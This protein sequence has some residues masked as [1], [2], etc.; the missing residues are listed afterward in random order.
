MSQT[1]ILRKTLVLNESFKTAAENMQFD[2]DC[3]ER[4]GQE[5]IRIFRWYK[6]QN[7][8]V[9]I[10]K[11]K[12]LPENLNHINYSERVS[13]GG[14]VFH[15]PNDIVFSITSTLDDERFPKKLKHKMDFIS[16]K[17]RQSLHACDI[18]TALSKKEEE[19]ID[20]NFCKSYFNPSE[21]TVNNQKVCG[22]SLRKK[23]DSFI[24]QGVI[25]VE[26]NRIHFEEVATIYKSFLT[27]GIQSGLTDRIFNEVKKI[28]VT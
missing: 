27:D 28:N 14:I 12:K 11:K 5:K 3:L 1:T 2:E 25:H 10:S 18:Q 13:G 4:V 24:I 21:I 16:E 22:M 6:W 20:Y 9:T 26:S 15:S 19:L 7:R 23:R 17:I 8:G